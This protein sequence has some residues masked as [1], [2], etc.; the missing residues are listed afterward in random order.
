MYG[1]VCKESTS[2]WGLSNGN[3][4]KYPCAMSKMSDV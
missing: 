3:L 4:A 1:L 2:M